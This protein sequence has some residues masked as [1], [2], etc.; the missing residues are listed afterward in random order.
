MFTRELS[1]VDI[2]TSKPKKKKQQSP[3][4]IAKKNTMVAQ[5]LKEWEIE[6]KNRGCIYNAK[7]QKS[8]FILGL[9]GYI[10]GTLLHFVSTAS[11]G[12]N[13]G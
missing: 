13:L 7:N 6:F 11:V 1:G 4:K 3:E 10:F 9:L 12:F 5:V 8:I 2:A